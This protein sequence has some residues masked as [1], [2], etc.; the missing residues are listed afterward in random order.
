MQG[1][2]QKRSETRGDRFLEL[3][4]TVDGLFLKRFLTIPEEA[5]SWEKFDL[6]T[7]INLYCLLADEFWDEELGQTDLP[8]LFD[9]KAN[10][11]R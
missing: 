9:F 5:W 10:Y 4:K 7:C 1:D 2:S 6:F 8:N 3:L 11:A